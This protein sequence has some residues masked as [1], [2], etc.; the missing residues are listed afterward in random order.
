[1]KVIKC[2]SIFMIVI[3]LLLLTFTLATIKFPSPEMGI[4]ASIAY[5]LT[6]LEF[7]LTICVITCVSSCMYFVA[8]N[9]KSSLYM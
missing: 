4:L 7:C 3:S 8:D 5:A 9:P 2:I 1:M 6:L